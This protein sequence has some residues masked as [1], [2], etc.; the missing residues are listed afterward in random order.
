M[1][2]S[3]RLRSEWNRTLLSDVC[4]AAYAQLLLRATTQLGPSSAYDALLPANKPAEPWSILVTKLYQA[5]AD[6]P[7]LHTRAVDA[8]AR[9]SDGGAAAG[10]WI[11]PREALFRDE[12]F[13]RGAALTSALVSEGL[14]VVEPPLGARTLL[15]EHATAG[16]ATVCTSAL[17]RAHLRGSGVHRG[18]ERRENA[19]TLLE[20][21][22]EDVLDDEAGDHLVNLQLVPLSDGTLGRFARRSEPSG[23]SQQ[24][25]PS[26]TDF[27]LPASELEARLLGGVPHR[28]VDEKVEGQLGERLRSIAESGGTNVR[29]L[30]API[31]GQLL[32]EIL[33]REW[34]G[35][36]HVAW[37]VL[38]A[39]AE[40]DPSEQERELR[41]FTQRDEL[42][43]AQSGR[44]V[45]GALVVEL[46]RQPSVNWLSDFWQW[47]GEKSR[48]DVRT[49]SDWPLLPTSDGGL[50]QLSLSSA[51]VGPGWE[52][53]ES[54][55]GGFPSGGSAE[56]T[57]S[58]SGDAGATLTEGNKQP[59]G[60]SRSNNGSTGASDGSS[61]RG[62]VKVLKKLG[63]RFL[64]PREAISV[65][66]HPLASQFLH[67]PTAIGILTALSAACES[68]GA[69]LV[70]QRVAKLDVLERASLR[71]FFTQPQWWSG[72]PVQTSSVNIL[73]SLPIFET[74]GSSPGGLVALASSRVFLP[75]KDVDEALLGESF[76]KPASETEAH[77]LAG[78]LGVPVL[79][80]AAF[81][82]AHVFGRILG[83]PADVRNKSMLAALR[84]L[85]GLCSEDA[86]FREIISRLPFVPAGG[87]NG[88]ELLPPSA[89]Y[90]P[91]V[92][93]LV[94]LLEGARS[95]GG[96][97]P[98]AG[99]T[100]KTDAASNGES[101]RRE[102]QE[103]SE[104]KRV[105]PTSSGF[106][107]RGEFATPQV[108][109]ALRF[110]GLKTSVS[111]ETVLA[112][113]RAVEQLA[114][115]DPDTALFQGRAILE[116]LEIHG[117]RWTPGAGEEVRKAF[118]KFGNYLGIK[119]ARASE[120]GL[121]K[122]WS[123]LGST[124]WCPVM[125]TPPDPS[126]PWPSVT[127]TVSAPR[128][129]RPASDMWLV[130]ASLRVLDGECR[131]AALAH[132]LGWD[133]SP[134]PAVLAAQ[135]LE[136]GKRH[137]H[138][139]GRAVGRQL[140]AAIPRIYT[141]L[142]QLLGREEMDI[143]KAVLE[144]SAWVWVGD[145]F[146]AVDQVAFTGPLNLAP[147]FFGTSLSLGCFCR[148]KI[149]SAF[150]C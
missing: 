33:P 72:A 117:Q 82:R 121:E 3:G 131:S 67:T 90:D 106:F 91:R 66:E 19:L 100:T 13:A 28:V 51:V 143:V 140:A 96:K 42:L 56:K 95:R 136:L 109:D 132:Q 10:R 138:V 144:G 61:L 146:A 127:G 88:D 55:T 38:G 23:T 2:G 64:H 60:Q 70:S 103:G 74:Y 102:S 86:S 78:S 15:M 37:E 9:R 58:L 83:L 43:R 134:G 35:K 4:T 63:C 52:V 44:R 122:F 31:L 119:E 141:L 137:A 85:P 17:V 77:T 98:P 41:L 81:Y 101:S 50:C 104:E 69:G 99:E 57:G 94:L 93:E 11:T 84:D 6:I 130:S 116:Y 111:Q 71:R 54:G 126:L 8:G 45:S 87:R 73:R 139:G 149:K 53:L 115:S 75:P 89:L 76:L 12:E 5:L 16:Q 32:S 46:S 62:L 107:P 34:R 118:S 7:I 114:G 125:V 110:L 145:G 142:H 14:P 30:S 65:S 129:C 40:L 113:A 108:L 112:A 47:L 105:L 133:K 25:E 135:L 123:D 59:E 26:G 39:N 21:C 1:E 29:I 79:G 36:R 120:T 97:E 80:R 24:F 22:L 147:Y 18:L 92:E 124:Q 48:G 148:E 150:R 27:V 68:D 20:Y 128:F 49:F